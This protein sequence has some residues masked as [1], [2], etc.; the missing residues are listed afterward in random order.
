MEKITKGTYRHYKGNL[1]EVMGIVIHSET[2]E[3][4]V[5]YKPLYDSK[6][7]PGALWVRPLHM[8]N[9]QVTVHGRMVPRFEKLSS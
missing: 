7:F 9:E 3:E 2:L 6:D 4:L 8:F 1:Y 5:L